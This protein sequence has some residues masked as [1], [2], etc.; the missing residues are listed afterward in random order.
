MVDGVCVIEA[1]EGFDAQQYAWADIVI[2]Q[3]S[4][5]NRAVR[6]AAR[7]GRPVVQM[8]Q[9]VGID[10]KASFGRPDLTVFDAEWLR[11]RRPVRG[12]SVVLHPLVDRT[13]YET[14]PGDAIR[15]IGM[16]EFKGVHTAYALAE[17]FVER[18]FLAAQAVGE[19]RWCDARCRRR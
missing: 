3:L 14:T 7:F 6:L 11:R 1:D 19:S 15:I 5:R 13:E 2:T 16:S 18:P 10:P 9:M 12:P 8:L 4:S 17:R